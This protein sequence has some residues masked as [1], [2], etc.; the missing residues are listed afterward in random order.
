[1]FFRMAIQTMQQI[2]PLQN[3]FLIDLKIKLNKKKKK[4]EKN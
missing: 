3:K 1:M 2:E 4:K